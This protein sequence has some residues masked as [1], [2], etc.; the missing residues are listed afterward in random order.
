MSYITTKELY[1]L[2]N[3]AFDSKKIMGRKDMQYE[4]LILFK[5]QN[6]FYEA[7]F[8]TELH[9]TSKDGR[10]YYF[11]VNLCNMYTSESRFITD[12][13]LSEFE[14]RVDEYERFVEEYL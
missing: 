6:M 11:I 4:Q 3:K 9:L 8:G 10:I 13:V 5:L 14:V 1:N 2:A 7:G 12:E